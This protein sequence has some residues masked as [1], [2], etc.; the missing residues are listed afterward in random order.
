MAIPQST[1]GTRA[2]LY[3]I[4]GFTLAVATCWVTELFDPPFSIMQVTIET[5]VIS[6]LG[7]YTLRSMLRF[8]QRLELTTI[9]LKQRHLELQEQ[10][11]QLEASRKKL[12]EL[13]E[14]KS[15]FVSLVSHELRTPLTSIIGF[16][17]TLMTLPLGAE[18]HRRYLGIIESEGKR[19]AE[20]VEEYLDMSKIESGHIALQLAP[21]DVVR[22]VH[23]VVEQIQSGSAVC[24]MTCLPAELPAVT[25]DVGRLKRVL[26]NLTDNALR[27]TAKGTSVIVSATAADDGPCVSVQ[28]HG[29]GLTPKEAARVFEKF[30]RGRDS[31]TERSR[32]SG[33]GLTIA[34][35]IVEAHGG[36][37]WV[38]SEPGQGATFR[39]WMPKER[40]SDARQAASLHKVHTSRSNTEDEEREG[41]PW[42]K[43]ES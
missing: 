30:Y 6:F 27:Y 14:L 37:L 38:E 9:E 5:L 16:S 40:A 3:G 10:A 12:M 35:G 32:G 11:A 25:G 39:F 15:D 2:L 29:P 18:Q 31:I 24:I 34:K 26:L 22:L 19:L 1:T 4:F 7:F 13:D 43:R 8:I 42:R 36:R 21:V 33:L 17:R 28:D 20:L 23:E 41:L